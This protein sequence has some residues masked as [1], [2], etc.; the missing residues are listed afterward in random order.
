VHGDQEGVAGL[1]DSAV[2][3]VPFLRPVARA[4]HNDGLRDDAT[5]DLIVDGYA[6]ALT[7][8]LTAEVTAL[9]ELRRQLVDVPVVAA[10]NERVMQLA[11]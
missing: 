8:L 1:D 9:A 11:G 4:Q 7:L 6:F 10:R 5:D 2:A 3:A